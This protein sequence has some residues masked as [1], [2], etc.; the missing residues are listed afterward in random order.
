MLFFIK[1]DYNLEG[2]YFRVPLL[3]G[4][5]SVGSVFFSDFFSR[6]TWKVRTQPLT[7]S[8]THDSTDL[9]PTF[10]EWVLS[11]AA[12]DPP[13]ESIS[14][15]VKSSPSSSKKKFPPPPPLTPPGGPKRSNNNNN[16]NNADQTTRS[17]VETRLRS[18]TLQPV[19]VESSSTASAP[20][21]HAVTHALRHTLALTHTHACAH[22][23]VWSSRAVFHYN[24]IPI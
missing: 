6:H 16:N 3:W 2:D 19:R 1:L 10:L 18:R 22:A 4:H 9:N 17:T 13:P 12:T 8:L 14:A 15:L 7:L 24:N 11:H 21:L 5:C 20:P 23:L